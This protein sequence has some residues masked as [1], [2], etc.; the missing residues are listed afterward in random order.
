LAA[1]ASRAAFTAG[2]VAASIH[3]KPVCE[4]REHFWGAGLGGR[5]VFERRRQYRNSLGN[6]ACLRH[7]VP[8]ERIHIEA[9]LVA[10]LGARFLEADHGNALGIRPTCGYPSLDLGNHCAG[11][12]CAR[13]R[14]G[15]FEFWRPSGTPV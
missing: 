10:R 6:D 13:R 3:A 1:A 9:A 14:A 8:V 12:L 5:I 7:V 15:Q 2:T 11:S 4:M